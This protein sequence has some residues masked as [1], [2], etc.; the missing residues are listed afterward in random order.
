[1][2]LTDPTPPSSAELA[3]AL[4]ARLCHDF[5]SPASAVVSGVDL[6]E[7]PDSQDLREDALQLIATSSRKLAASLQFCRVA[8]GASSAADT[9]D[10][11]QLES[12]TAGVFDH[13]RADLD[14]AVD[15]DGAP[16]PVARSL[17]NLAQ[18]GGA[19][20]P[21]GGTA[22]VTAKLEDGRY[23]LAV[24]A[25]GPRARLRPEVAEGLAGMAMTEGLAGH[26]VQ[27]YYLRRL[28]EEAGGEVAFE[29][30]DTSVAIRVSLPAPVNP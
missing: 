12:L 16:K 7:D 11:R 17:L 13:M 3:A 8:F 22:R 15:L 23:D 19:A 9:F 25:E 6:L 4:A 27:S 20:L 10:V 5:I 30:G 24:L 1:M 2:T 26:W 29:T 18:L 21:T 14:W 28:V